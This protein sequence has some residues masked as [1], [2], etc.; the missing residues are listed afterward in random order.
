MRT[1]ATLLTSACI[2]AAALPAR[3]ENLHIAAAIS[4]KESL[5]AAAEAFQ[6]ST[7]TTVQF[8]FGSSGAMVAQIKNGAKD[9][10]FISAAAPQM[11]DLAAAKLLEPNTRRIVAL[12]ELVIVVPADSPT[13]PPPADFRALTQPAYKKIALGE[14]TTV[15][16]GMY[17]QEVL[18]HLHIT[19]ALKNKLVYGTNVRQV[20]IYVERGEVEAGIVYR[21]DALA[22]GTQ[23]K[24]AATADP[25]D[26]AP[27][28]YPAAV[29]AESEHKKTALA[30]LDF[31]ATPA[32]KAL[33]IQKGFGIPAPSAD[34]GS[35]P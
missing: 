7:G 15:P 28:E 2:A 23:V 4:M 6:K 34:K 35:T 24:V 32:G 11:D 19:D 30:F 9:D 5:E 31:L 13:P 10:A 27:I 17:A 26:H 1:L 25:H 29:L 3:A 18:D 22:A 20:L 8:H 21:T 16:A 12:N 14:P 33:L